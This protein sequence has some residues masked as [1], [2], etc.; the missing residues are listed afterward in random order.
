MAAP[1][2][3]PRRWELTPLGEDRTQVTET[4]DYSRVGSL[5]GRGLEIYGAPARNAKGIEA[6]LR[7]LQERFPRPDGLR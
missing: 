5:R 2:R 4:F 6:M 1:A 3:P 7:Q